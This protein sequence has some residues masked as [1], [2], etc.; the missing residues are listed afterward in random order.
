[1]P[2]SRQLISGRSD[3]EPR[4]LIPPALHKVMRLVPNKCL[5]DQFQKTLDQHGKK[6]KKRQFRV[7]DWLIRFRGRLRKN[8]VRVGTMEPRMTDDP[9]KERLC[10]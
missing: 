6:G 1:M 2:K 8:G 4:A 7:R 5:L 3:F 9:G 10:K